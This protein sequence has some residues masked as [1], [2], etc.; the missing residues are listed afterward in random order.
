MAFVQLRNTGGNGFDMSIYWLFFACLTLLSFVQ[1]KGRGWFAAIA[2]VLIAW[3]GLRYQVG[4]DWGTY[5][6]WVREAENVAITTAFDGMDPA[7][8]LVNWLGANGL[9][10]IYFV[11]LLC[12]TLAVVP[13]VVFCSTRK[14][15][16]LALLVA[17]P[18]LVTV[19]YMNY[20]RQSV[21]IGFGMLALLSVERQ[22]IGTFLAA[23][24]LAALFHK[25]ALCLFVIAPALFAGNI[26]RSNIIKLAWIAAYGAC[27]ALILLWEE[28]APIYRQYVVRTGDQVAAVEGK[29]PSAGLYSAGAVLRLA[30]AMVASVAFCVIAWRIKLQKAELWLWSIVSLC[31]LALFTLAFVRSTLADRVGLFFIPLQLYAFATLPDVAPRRLSVFVQLAIV[32][33]LAAA[34]GVWLIYGSDTAHWLPYQS[35]IMQVFS[36]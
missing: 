8:G 4:T 24:T 25:S 30:Q 14:N 12:A 18:Y 17:F 22:R 7:Y 16:F 36:Q 10:G 3:V 28:A 27:L 2:V 11:N 20:T 34:F 33:C 23:V 13:L 26:N 15:P 31:V 9:G 6:G 5:V 1:P 35:I 32:A 21:A 19:V 29:P